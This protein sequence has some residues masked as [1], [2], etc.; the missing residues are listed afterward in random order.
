MPK[1]QE[2]YSYGKSPDTVGDEAAYMNGNSQ[3]NKE[4]SVDDQKKLEDFLSVKNVS[5]RVIVSVGDF[6]KVKFF[7]DNKPFGAYQSRAFKKEDAK[8]YLTDLLKD[9]TDEQK[10]ATVK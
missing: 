1:V 9:S 7:R 5:A 8:K 4:W 10:P 6:V 2:G 3:N